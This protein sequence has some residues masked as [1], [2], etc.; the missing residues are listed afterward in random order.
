MYGL[1]S[2]IIAG[3]RE[4][5]PDTGIGE[6]L[7]GTA[8]ETTKAD[9]TDVTWADAVTQMNAA[10]RESG[11]QYRLGDNKLPVLEQNQ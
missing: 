4:S 1:L 3:Y 10:L 6:N 11:R 7:G 2:T 9:G 8:I 5:N